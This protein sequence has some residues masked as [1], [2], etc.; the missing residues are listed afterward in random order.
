MTRLE[1]LQA[2][3]IDIATDFHTT[4]S[5]DLPLLELEYVSHYAHL[6][7]VIYT[8]RNYDTVGSLID[9]LYKGVFN[10]IGIADDEDVDELVNTTFKLIY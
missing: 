1:K 4:I 7:T 6:G 5:E 8:I 10:E 3:L 2:E 9:D